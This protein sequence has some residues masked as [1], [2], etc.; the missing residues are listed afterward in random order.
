MREGLFY[1]DDMQWSVIEG[2]LPSRK[3]RGPRR[4]DD[5]RIVSGI[6]HVLQS[7][8]RWRDCPA[9]YGPCTTVYNRFARW[10][11]QGIWQRIFNDLG[12]I[13]GTHYSNSIDSTSIKAH[14]SARGKKG[15]VKK[16]SASAG[17][18]APPRST[19]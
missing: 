1:L 5:R 6:I 9:E 2:L 18:A 19:R 17:A 7:G 3:R 13:A 11:K 8:M 16:P 14:R 12:Q 15:A 10:S 4:L